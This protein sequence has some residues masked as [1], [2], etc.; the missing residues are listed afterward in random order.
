MST[1]LKQCSKCGAWKP[2]TADHFH[3]HAAS[4]DGLRPECKECARQRTLSYYQRNSE[5]LREASREWRASNRERHRA[6]SRQWEADHPEQVREQARRWVQKNPE[7]RRAAV[8]RYNDAHKE[9][10][11]SYNREWGQRTGYWR[12]YRAENADRVRETFRRWCLRNPEKVRAARQRRRELERA[13]GRFTG[14]EWRALCDWFGG[15]CLACGASDL[16]TADHVVPL[17][18]GGSNHISNIQPLCRDCNNRKNTATTD[19]RDREHFEAFLAMLAS[20]E[21]EL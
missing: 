5:R 7:R 4:R 12:R 15:I 10:K 17:S 9:E 2:R 21:A 8:K 1:D 18:R 6:Y 20:S 11:A 13:G 3:R 14:G 19:Y 16:L